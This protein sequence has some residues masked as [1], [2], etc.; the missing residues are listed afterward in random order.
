MGEAHENPETSIKGKLGDIRR[1]PTNKD[2]K[3]VRL[4]V[5]K[6]VKKIRSYP[7]KLSGACEYHYTEFHQ[8]LNRALG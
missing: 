2:L 6:I 3:R 4:D 1:R 7:K 5:V 8:I